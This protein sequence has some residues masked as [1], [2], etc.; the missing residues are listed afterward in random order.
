M[1]QQHQSLIHYMFSHLLYSYNQLDQN[2]I[3]KQHHMRIYNLCNSILPKKAFLPKKLYDTLWTLDIHYLQV[4]NIW[5]LG[6]KIEMDLCT[7]LMLLTFHNILRVY[8]SW[9]LPNNIYDLSM[10]LYLNALSNRM[11][12]DIW[13]NS[14][15][16]LKAK[17]CKNK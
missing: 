15:V 10:F 8:T 16:Q 14:P 9:I 3:L 1:H 2:N 13:R 17:S 5:D 12:M 6:I 7:H 4:H 11:Q